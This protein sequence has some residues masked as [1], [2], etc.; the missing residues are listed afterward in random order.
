M[1][2]T[3]TSLEFLMLLPLPIECWIT[4]MCPMPHFSFSFA[5]LFSVWTSED[6]LAS[7]H[8]GDLLLGIEVVV[9]SGVTEN[10]TGLCHYTKCFQTVVFNTNTHTHTPFLRVPVF[11]G[12]LLPFKTQR[13]SEIKNSGSEVPR[14]GSS[15]F[16]NFA[17]SG[18][19]VNYLNL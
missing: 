4:G 8:K 14:P 12:P 5:P 11:P 19:Q 18:S 13:S 10:E 7:F 2:V 15:Q 9:H 1:L 16:C 3:K 17:M 6:W